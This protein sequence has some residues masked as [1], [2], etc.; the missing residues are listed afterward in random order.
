M[1]APYRLDPADPTAFP[2]A[3]LALDDPDGLLAV[4]GDLSPERLLAAYRQGIFPW[5]SEGQPILWWSPDPRTVLYPDR[6]HVSR[7]LART[8][9]RTALRFTADHA[10]E[11]VV[12]GC[13]EPRT[14][15]GGTWITGAMA[16][17]YARLHRLGRAHSVEVWDG[18]RLVGGIYGVAMGRV[19][20]GESMFSRVRDASK[21]A[22]VRLGERLTTWGYRLIDAQV[23][24]PHLARLGAE[25]LPRSRF[26]ELLDAY[27]SEGDEAS[28]WRTRWDAT[29]AHHGTG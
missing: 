7:R 19:F 22:M 25:T 26:L 9:R 17:A 12:A 15:Q 23:Y 2:P 10:F 24:N 3:T 14:G 18:D 13:A 21:M 16:Q 1:A 5:Y 29:E 4:G 8:L 11:A 27:C 28:S 6:I 20:F